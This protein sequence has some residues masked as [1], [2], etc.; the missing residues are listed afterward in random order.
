M[1]FVLDLQDGVLHWLDVQA[2]GQLEMNNVE[3]SKS[4]IAKIRPDLTNYFGSGVRPWMYDLALLHAA[5]RC[6]CVTVRGY[7][8]KQFF[9][10]LPSPL[11]SSSVASPVSRHPD[12]VLPAASYEEPVFAALYQ[13]DIELPN[14]SS[15]YALF[16]EQITPTNAA[17]DLL[18]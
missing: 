5:A 10:R 2:K 17:R 1:P 3:S 6:Q 16:R 8:V 7:G 15:S 14:G 9:R 11:F 4:A 13:G 12:Q 18:S